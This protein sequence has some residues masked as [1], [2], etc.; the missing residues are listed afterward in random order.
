MSESAGNG[1]GWLS[2][3]FEPK[4]DFYEMMVKHAEK[5]LEGV[6]ALA[7]WIRNGATDRCQI[8]RDLEKDADG[9][10]LLLEK[11][12]VDS[13]VTPMDREDIY[14]LAARM[15][16]VIN[17][18][19]STVREIESLEVSPENTH[20]AEMAGIL[21][22]GTRCLVLAFRALKNQPQEAASQATLSRKSENR[23]TKVYRLAMQQLFQNDDFKTVLKTREVYRS[24][25]L[26]AE[27][28]DVV[29]EKLAHVIVKI[30]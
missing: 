23:F 14:D 28:M 29:G 6:E 4:V 24:M 8:V 16:E 26:I 21:E 11:K 18:A 12:L 22:E 27:R 20:I 2:R 30:S 1:H 17:A 25:M 13:F 9:L 3:V 5:T 7:D 19:K 10:R 15:D